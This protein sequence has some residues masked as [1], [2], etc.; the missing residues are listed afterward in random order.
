MARLAAGDTFRHAVTFP[1]GL[2]IFEMG[3]IFE[4]S[5]LGPARAFVLA[6]APGTE[7][8]SGRVSNGVWAAILVGDRVGFHSLTNPAT[9]F[10][11]K[12]SG[13]SSM[14][15]LGRTIVLFVLVSRMDCAPRRSPATEF[16]HRVFVG[17]HPAG[18]RGT[19]ME[20]ERVAG[21]N[22]ADAQTPRAR[23]PVI[24]APSA[25]EVEGDGIGRSSGL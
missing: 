2:T 25:T 19:L 24:T 5:G 3:D 21:K 1:E 22:G 12:F 16:F 23:R 14:V 13:I 11:G 18:D 7:Q 8:I 6:L 20:Y 10:T 4:R 17:G 15:P 9:N